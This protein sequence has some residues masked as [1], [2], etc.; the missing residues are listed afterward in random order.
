M[1]LIARKRFGQNFLIDQGIINK[2][3]TFIDPQ[4]TDHVLEIGPGK[5]ALTQHLLAT[6]RLNLVEIDRD[7][8][9]IL[10]QNYKQSHVYIYAQDILNFDLSCVADPSLKIVGNLPYNI[11]SQIIIKL[12]QS[13]LRWQ[14][15]FFMVQKEMAL[16]ICA[17]AHNK[18]YGR[19]TLITQYFADPQ[20]LCTIH[21][22]SFSPRPKVDSCFMVF[23][24]RVPKENIQDF[25]MFTNILKHA[26]NGRRKM[27]KKSLSALA[28]IEELLSCHIE[29]TLR[30]ENITLEQYVR[31]SNYLTERQTKGA[32]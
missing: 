24:P 17:A 7:L 25:V 27:I 1:R 13:G 9:K 2:I 28:T 3:V 4:L 21:G 10:Q 15:M 23:V 29:S 8:V 16:R 5:G 12:L 6:K 19:L 26:F 20:I 11:A 22:A 31:L 32:N 14:K 18:H 30:A